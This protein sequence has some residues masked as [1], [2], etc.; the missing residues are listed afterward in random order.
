MPEDLHT[1]YKSSFNDSVIETLVAFAN[2]KGG[3]VLVGVDDKCVPLKQ[4]SIGKE[5]IQQY[6]NEIKNKTQPAI[7]PN[8]EMVTVK[9]VSVLEFLIQEFPVKP[10]SFKGRY[11]KRVNNSNHQL[12][13]TEISDMSMQSLQLSWDSYLSPHCS[14]DD[15]DI[16]KIEKFIDKT[17]QIGRFTLEGSPGENLEKLR[18]IHKY[19]VSNAAVLLFS[20][21]DTIYNVHLG[22]FKTPSHII[23]DKMLRGTLFDVVEETMKYIVSHIKVAFE[24][25]GRT[26]QRT[27]IFEYPLAALRELVLNAIIHRDYLSP[28]D[29][30][31]KIFDT[32]ITFFNPGNLFGNLKIDDLKKDNYQAYARNK[33]IAEAFYLTGDIEKYGSGFIRIR[34]EVKKYPTMQ[35][36]FEEIPNGFL[37]TIHYEKQKI[38]LS[39]DN[40]VENGV[41][42]VVDNVVEKEKQLLE[43][44][45]VNKKISAQEMAVNLQLSPRTVQRYLKGLQDKGRLERIGSA[46]GGYWKIK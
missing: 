6:I 44:I 13:P 3:K 8:V 30:Q 5:T 42:N 27:E 33:L 36:S 20:K 16:L 35:F 15:L 26:T 19:Q 9:G 46:K 24:I 22:R 11:F 2:S 21:G 39:E 14:I 25:T 41:D 32:K 34:K 28:L 40:V 29:I 18:L 10:V 38:H 23:D 12:S 31:I 37:A 4:F 17:N 43:L 7:I 45:Q 1:E